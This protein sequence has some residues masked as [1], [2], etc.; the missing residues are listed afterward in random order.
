MITVDV[1]DTLV[2]DQEVFDSM[3]K[4]LARSATS[5]TKPAGSRSLLVLEDVVENG[6]DAR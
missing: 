2:L 6:R 5:T 3:S 4:G 1:R